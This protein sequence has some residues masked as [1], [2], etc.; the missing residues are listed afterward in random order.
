MKENTNKDIFKNCGESPL[1]IV[2][3]GL[4][5]FGVLAP[6]PYGS[7]LLTIF[8]FLLGGIC[9]YNYSSCG[10]VHCQITGYGFIAVGIVS[11][12]NIFNF[13]PGSDLSVWTIFFIILGIG[14]GYEYIY[15]EKTGS[16]YKK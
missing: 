3:L 7:I 16:Q 13:I 15:K 6:Y 1:F 14:Y 2:L 10:R 12:L 4:L 9:Y 8:F 11:L 5:L